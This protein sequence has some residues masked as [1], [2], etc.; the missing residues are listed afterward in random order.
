MNYINR[1]FAFHSNGRPM[2]FDIFA[3]ILIYPTFN[4]HEQSF[5]LDPDGG[6]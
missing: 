2:K 3:A 4:A 1:A 6:V 5:C